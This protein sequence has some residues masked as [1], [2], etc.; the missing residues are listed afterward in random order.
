MM[1]VSLS[2]GKLEVDR[3]TMEDVFVQVIGIRTIMLLSV[4]V[5]ETEGIIVRG[6]LKQQESE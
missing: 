2:E 4:E 3:R 1:E 6:A 5:I